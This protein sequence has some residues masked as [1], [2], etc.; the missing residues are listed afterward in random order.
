M[1]T[2]LTGLTKLEE[3][4]NNLKA[5]IM[6]ETELKSFLLCLRTDWDTN[7]F[8][9][10]NEMVM[11]FGIKNRTEYRKINF[12]RRDLIP[13]EFADNLGGL[14][15]SGGSK[16]VP[17]KIREK[18]VNWQLLFTPRAKSIIAWYTWRV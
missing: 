12:S 13:K 14:S 1:T 4:V 10:S 7:H 6:D 2:A 15:D 18:R 11:E 8:F 16:N 3:V 17:A 9:G 5:Y